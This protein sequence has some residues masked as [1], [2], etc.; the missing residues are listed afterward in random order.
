MKSTTHST[1]FISNQSTLLFFTI[2]SASCRCHI[3]ASFFHISLIHAFQ[4][5]NKTESTSAAS[6]GVVF[7][8]CLSFSDVHTLFMPTTAHISMRRSHTF[9]WL[10][11]FS[12]LVFLH[13][14]VT[15]TNSICCFFFL[16][17]PFA[18][19]ST[20]RDRPI[21]VHLLSF[22]ASLPPCILA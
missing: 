4:T 18:C 22:S 19:H 1:C 8:P 10:L 15:I 5:S 7:H 20:N 16:S 17:H 21:T 2:N 3:A 12:P 13:P 9:S 14:A 6:V 11:L